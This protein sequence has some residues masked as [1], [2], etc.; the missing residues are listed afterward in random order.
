MAFGKKSYV[1]AIRQLGFSSAAS[2]FLA[3][4]G[5][6]F[7]GSRSGF[8]FW[9]WLNVEELDFENEGGVRSNFWWRSSFAIGEVGR[10]EELELGADRHELQT[11]GPTGNDSV[12]GELDGLAAVDRTIED[13]SVRKGAV[14]VNFDGVS[15]Q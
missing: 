8:G 15:R 12:E 11:F 4:R 1:R 9:L 14:V 6:F 7:G 3:F 5:W 10:N 13:G 2:G